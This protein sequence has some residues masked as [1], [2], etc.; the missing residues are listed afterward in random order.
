VSRKNQFSLTRVAYKNGPRKKAISYQLHLHKLSKSLGFMGRNPHP[1]AMLKLAKFAVAV[2][3]VALVGTIVWQVLQPPETEPVY[4]GKP[5]SCWL[6]GYTHWYY[7]MP[8]IAKGATTKG[9]ADKAVLQAGTNAIPTLLRLLRVR[10]SSLKLK[11]MDLAKK[12]HFIKI[13]HPP[14]EV[15]NGAAS[16]A[17][18]ILRTNAQSAVL[19]LIGIVKQNIS[20]TSQSCAVMSLGYMGPTAKEALPSLL[21]WATNVDV[22][23]STNA[24]HALLFIDAE[25]AAKAGIT[26]W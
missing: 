5:L 1:A 3:F 2:V 8:P 19:A 11:L 25:A 18:G 26:N 10:D 6:L 7:Q 17:F 12:Q 20:P 14:A 16:V 9:E 4:Q 22:N 24:R 21:R 15:W 23:V 13:D